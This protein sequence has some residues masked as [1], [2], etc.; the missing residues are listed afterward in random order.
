VSLPE[1]DLTLPDGEVLNIPKGQPIPW[2]KLPAEG[3]LFVTRSKDD[4]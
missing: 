2:E 3:V 1:G 4:D